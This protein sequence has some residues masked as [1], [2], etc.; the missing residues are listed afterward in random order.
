[1]LVE[2]EDV[3]Q[4]SPVHRRRWFQDDGMELIVWYDP[5][6]GLEG[7]QICYLIPGQKE[8][9][10]TWRPGGGFSHATVDNGESRPDKNLT[11]ILVPDGAVPWDLL[12][13]EFA[14][15]STGMEPALRARVLGSLQRRTA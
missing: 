15:R 3:K 10:L 4:E 13:S 2:Y 7:F 14:Q 12:Q 5:A 1:M 11:P 9:A 8:R 6:G